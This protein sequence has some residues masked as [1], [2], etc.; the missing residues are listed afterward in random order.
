MTVPN[1]AQTDICTYLPTYGASYLE[2]SEKVP[3]SGP[4]GGLTSINTV[5][6]AMNSIMHVQKKLHSPVKACGKWVAVLVSR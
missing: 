6:G 3:K 1:Y 2:A 4:L 5:N